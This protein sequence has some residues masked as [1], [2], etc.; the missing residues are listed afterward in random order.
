MHA[1]KLLLTTIAFAACDAAVIFG[2]Q[3]E[4][5]LPRVANPVYNA[6]YDSNYGIAGD[7]LKEAEKDKRTANPV[8]NAPY[9]SNYGIAGDGLKEAEKDKRTANPVYNAPYDSNY[10]IAGDGLKEAEKN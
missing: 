8:Y 3:L 2:Q 9:D 1:H 10:G 7:G 4:G 5:V 6:P